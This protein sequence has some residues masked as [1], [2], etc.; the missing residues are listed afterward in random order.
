MV[1]KS[2]SIGTMAEHLQSCRALEDLIEASNTMAVK[3]AAELE[4]ARDALEKLEP[5]QHPKI[6]TGVKYDCDCLGDR[7]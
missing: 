3:L 2:K 1:T 4:K 7:A 5:E 6:L